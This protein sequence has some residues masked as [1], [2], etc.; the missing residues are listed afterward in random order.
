MNVLGTAS[1]RAVRLGQF[2]QHGHPG[3]YELKVHAIRTDGRPRCGRWVQT[4]N[5][6]RMD[7][8]EW[9]GDEDEVTCANC[10]RTDG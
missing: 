8:V 10:G 4:W 2:R 1:R 9:D 5:G 7:L 6:N 3:P